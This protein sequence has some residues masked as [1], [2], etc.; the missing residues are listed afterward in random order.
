MVTLRPLVQEGLVVLV[1]EQ[2]VPISGISG[3][4]ITTAGCSILAM[5]A[6]DSG[7]ICSGSILA[8]W[9]IRAL[10]TSGSAG[11]LRRPRGSGAGFS[12]NHVS[13]VHSCP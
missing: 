5:G 4:G 10:G 2:E 11:R 12:S 8:F 3:E 1:Q 7:I 9:L 6:C 13:P